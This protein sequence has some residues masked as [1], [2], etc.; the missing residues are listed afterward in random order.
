MTATL[1]RQVPPVGG[2]FVDRATEFGRVDELAAPRASGSAATVVVLW[3]GHGVGK[4]AMTRKWAHAN[5]ARYDHG[6]LYADFGA[7]RHTGGV[8]VTDVLSGFLRALGVDER[9]IPDSLAERSGLFRSHLV[10]RRVL[11]VLDDV[12]D[13]AEVRPFIPASAESTVLVTSRAEMRDLVA[14]DGASIVVLRPLDDASSRQLLAEMLGETRVSAEPGPSARLIEICGGLP[15]ALRVCAAQLLGSGEGRPIVW[16]A[17]RLDDRSRRLDELTAGPGRSLR[18]VFDEA[19]RALPK[20]QVL[21]YRILGSLPGRDFCTPLA[22]SVARIDRPAAAE[23]LEELAAAHLLE[24]RDAR[25][26]FHDLI[27]DH[28]AMTA[29]R[30]EDRDRLDEA[31][32]SAA[33]WYVSAAENMDRAITPDRLRMGSTATLTQPGVPTFASPAEALRWFEDE[34]LNLVATV[35]ASLEQGF[36]DE[37]WRLAEAMWIAYVNHKHLDEAEEVYRIAVTAAQRARRVDVE[38]RMR[39]QRARSLID[40]GQLDDAEDELTTAATLAQDADH[41]MLAASVTEFVGVLEIHRGRGDQAVD[42]L[43]S[44]RQAFAE[45]GYTRGIVLQNYLLGRA[46]LVNGEPERAVGSLLLALRD[47]DAEADPMTRARI[48][49]RLG[50]AQA[51]AG[52]LAD[53]EATLRQAAMVTREHDAPTYAAS[54]LEGLAD[55]CRGQE[56]HDEERVHLTEARGILERLGSSPEVERISRRLEELAG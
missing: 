27:R 53:A 6:Q 56:R 3:G 18:A 28:A 25:F 40:L 42:A 37:T 45:I 12:Q 24:R 19:V 39:Q 49:T 26:G 8:L 9:V 13:A 48:L 31:A 22:A 30:D 11:V 29:D 23:L 47:V 44:A 51:A 17:D 16:L 5:S 21:L 20:P 52:I 43:L 46:W 10:G 4:S 32:R 33:R 34:R 41:P 1:P 2:P 54:A 35:R 14:F 38:G 36:D 55:L 50:Q 7:H 15:V